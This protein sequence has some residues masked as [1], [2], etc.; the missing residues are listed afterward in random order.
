M[1]NTPTMDTNCQLTL[2]FQPEC[3]LCDEAEVLIAALGLTERVK[4]VNI[5][6]DL[7]LLKRYGFTVPVLLR[8]EDRRELFWP[9]GVE[10]LERFAVA[11]R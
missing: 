11:G 3:H 10:E 8:E 2:F 7:E 6:D 9:F 1:E 4:R 5:E